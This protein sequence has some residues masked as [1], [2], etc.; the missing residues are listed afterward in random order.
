M[1]ITMTTVRVMEVSVDQIVNM[2][3]VGYSLVTAIRA[4]YM[5]LR[6]ARAQVLRRTIFGV[7]ACYFYYMF[8]NVILVLVVQ[9][10][11]MQVIDMII[12]HDTRVTALR[13]VWM[14]MIFVQVTIG[15]L[16]FPLKI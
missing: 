12:M 11:V 2:S 9:M 1:I 5:R 16:R 7:H 15:H 4:V 14:S 6:V 10:S 3:A 8:I 13:P